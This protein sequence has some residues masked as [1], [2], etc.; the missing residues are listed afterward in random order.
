L[1]QLSGDIFSRPR[2]T[3]LAGLWGIGF[4]KLSFLKRLPGRVLP[5]R[6]YDELVT[7]LLDPR[8]RP[9]LQ[10]CSKISAAELAIIAHF[11]QPIV[12]A[13]S[14]PIISKIGTELFDYV[15]G[16]LR[17]HRPDLDDLGLVAVL[18]ELRRTEDLS[19]WLRRVLRHADLPAPPWDGSET[20][21]PLRT[22]AEI[23]VTGVEMRNCLFDDDRSLSAVLGQCCYYRISGRYGPAVVSVA[24]DALLGTWRIQSY[25]GPA[26]ATV[27]PAAERFI[28]EAFAAV[29][30]RFFGEYP[31]QR[32]LEWCDD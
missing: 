16:V 30:I 32:A 27:K 19:A 1:R 5:R 18:R 9:L 3:V 22:V 13:A 7:A 26:N 24:H 28:L 6:Q 29:G 12:A 4:G 8:L 20:I 25:R 14:L 11:D 17:R 21:S 23:H 31:R 2:P 10:Q 15:V